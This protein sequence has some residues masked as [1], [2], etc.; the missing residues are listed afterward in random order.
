MLTT[1]KCAY[2][3]SQQSRNQKEFNHK[4]HEEKLTKKRSFYKVILYHSM[5]Y[6]SSKK[7]FKGVLPFFPQQRAFAA[8]AFLFC[9]NRGMGAKI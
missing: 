7:G 3:L 9:S 1:L 4:G 2:I 5:Y 8:F 6:D